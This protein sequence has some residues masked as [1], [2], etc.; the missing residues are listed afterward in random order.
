[1]KN[2]W[3][4]FGKIFSFTFSQ[5]MQSKG[6]RVATIL[7][8]LLCLL[9]P[10][11]VITLIGTGDSDVSEE[12]ITGT[13]I[14][15]VYVVD[16]TGEAEADWNILSAIGAEGFDE[17]QYIG[18]NN[19]D[20]AKT[21]ALK[22]DT[23]AILVLKK[24]AYGYE[25][26]IVIPDGSQLAEDDGWALDNFIYQNFPAILVAKS[27]LNGEQLTELFAPSHSTI[28]ASE[29]IEE[30]GAAGVKWVLSMILPY[31]NVMLIY[32]LVLFYGQSVANE[33]VLEKSSKLMDTF[34]VSVRPAAMIM[35]KV[36]AVT[37]SSALQFIIWIAALAAGFGGGCA[38][39]K[40]LDPDTDFALVL[41]LEGLGD[42]SG[43]LSWSGAVVGVLLILA[44]FF[45]YCSLAAIGGAIA[46][47]Q[48]DL[49]STNVIFTLVLVVSF[50]ATLMNG[51]LFDSSG[52][53]V[54]ALNLIPFTSILVL[55]ANLFLGEA[56]VLAGVAALILVL[57]TSV[58]IL[59]LA[60]KIYQMM[61]FYK[62]NV[63]TAG[64]VLKMVFGK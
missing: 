58:L 26:T 49:S 11:A 48:E 43:L 7:I 4:G 57:V 19:Y 37:L 17:I 14:E 59:L 28:H 15:T 44:G 45:L 62:G 16:E 1:M 33:V 2:K 25:Y 23:A 21:E 60:G 53:T 9:L 46:G 42:Y 35:G 34:L 47:K 6:Y 41:L 54:S 55:P 5:Q 10:F 61:S 27:G 12:E 64:Q 63:P 51:G 56:S 30:G 38:F 20:S 18:G 8:A 29:D 3:S 31:V 40:F 13:G 39:V 52:N 24:N 50:F 22:T 36:F 32:F